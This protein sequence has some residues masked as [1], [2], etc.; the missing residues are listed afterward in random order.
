MGSIADTS[1]GSDR[2]QPLLKART[3]VNAVGDVATGRSCLGAIL[4]SI[5]LVVSLREHESVE[6]GRALVLWLALGCPSCS[7]PVF[8]VQPW[9]ALAL[10]PVPGVHAGRPGWL[11]LTG[12]LPLL[13]LFETR[14]LPMWVDDRSVYGPF[15]AWVSG[16]SCAASAAPAVALP[17]LTGQPGRGIIPTLDE[18][19]SLPSVLVRLPARHG[20]RGRRRRRR[21][22]G[23]A[24]PDGPRYGRRAV[25]V[26][27]RRGLR[28]GVRRR[29]WRATDADVVVF[30]D[31][32]G[33]DDPPLR[34]F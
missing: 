12:T 21:L 29:R 2:R 24:R 26:E 28:T 30:L 25:V 13:Y 9:H 14:E 5:V 3:S 1:T 15:A 20:R 16:G 8:Y 33:S 19:D 4:L 27:P 32:D 7:S 17:P 18:I 11:W 10:L 34:R 6:T 31:G 23:T 22:A